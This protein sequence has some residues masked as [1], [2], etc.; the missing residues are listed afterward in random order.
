MRGHHSIKCVGRR[1]NPLDNLLKAA[2]IKVHIIIHSKSWCGKHVSVNLGPTGCLILM[3]KYSIVKYKLKVKELW[4]VSL[5]S[6][7]LVLGSLSGDKVPTNVYTIVVLQY[8]FHCWYSYYKDSNIE[9]LHCIPH[10]T[11]TFQW[12]R[13]VLRTVFETSEN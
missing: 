7:N 6:W 5:S 13:D 1:C 3:C 4:A 2:A 9:S 8:S 12:C 11:S 10:Q